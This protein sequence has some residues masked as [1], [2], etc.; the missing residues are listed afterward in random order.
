LARRIPVSRPEIKV[1]Y[2]S[3]YTDTAIV[4]LGILEEGANFLQK[5]F[6][7]DGFAIKV[8][9][10]LDAPRKAHADRVPNSQR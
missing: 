4:H 8:R 6:S 2:M 9:E 7:T 10:V 3:G 5:P 1:L